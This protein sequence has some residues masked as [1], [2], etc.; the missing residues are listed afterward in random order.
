MPFIDH[1]SLF[2]I[3]GN[4]IIQRYIDIT[5]FISL[6]HKKALF[7]TRVDKQE[8]PFE[9]TFSKPS[10]QARLDWLINH[11]KNKEEEPD[12]IIIEK[13]LKEYD[14]TV[15][16]L[17]SLRTLNCWHKNESESALMWKSYS[18]VH[19]GIMIKSSFENLKSSLMGASETVY[20]SG[21]K[22]CNYEEYLMYSDNDFIPVIHKQSFYK[23]ENEI[24]AIHTVPDI[25]INWVHDWAKEESEFG[26][27]I[28]TDLNLLIN[29]IVIAPFA[30][31]WYFDLVV[32]LCEKY[33]L[34]KPIIK[35][36][37]AG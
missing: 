16:R 18:S 21:V 29:E 2:R 15:F 23:D 4:P 32:S 3:E 22:Y 11:Y 31:K 19:S 10:Y 13:I 6:L 33:N 8:D 17:K 27:F 34:D 7:F 14:A 25:D 30:P 12:R 1:P 5:K 36:A 20:I 9:G 28:N 26:V 37:L 35:S 24:R